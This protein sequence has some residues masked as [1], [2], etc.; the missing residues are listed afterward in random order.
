[1]R[2][3]LATLIVLAICVPA[4]ANFVQN[5]DF[6]A[7]LANWTYWNAPWGTVNVDDAGC[8]NPGN[9][10]PSAH[11]STGNGSGGLYQIVT[12]PIGVQLTIDADWTGDVGNAGWHELIVAEAPGDPAA[13]MDGPAGA[14]VRAKKDSWG[15]N[16]PPNNYGWESVTLS[17]A[18]FGGG[19]THTSASGQIIV[20][21]KCGGSGANSW[22]CFDNIE[23]IPEPATVALLGLG[24]LAL[25][26]RRK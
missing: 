9:P 6:S 4:S 21:T 26:R 23:V 3:I 5:G 2:K 16:T 10:E 12:V 24:G 8:P 20:G 22:V 1:M 17:D 13:F 14:H 18:G 11:H 15:L 25:V 7:G 19:F